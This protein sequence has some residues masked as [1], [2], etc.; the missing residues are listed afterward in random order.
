M[1]IRIKRKKKYLINQLKNRMKDRGVKLIIRIFIGYIVI[2]F[3]E[4]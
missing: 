1:K 3:K 2:S 4:A